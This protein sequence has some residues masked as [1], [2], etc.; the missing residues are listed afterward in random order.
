MKPY[1]KFVDKLKVDY[2]SFLSTP[3]EVWVDAATK[4]VDGLA[5][6]ELRR[7]VDLGTR[8]EYGAFLQIAYWQGIFCI[9]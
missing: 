3:K 4:N 6:E 2:R 5:G 7:L 9:N 1:S 8:R